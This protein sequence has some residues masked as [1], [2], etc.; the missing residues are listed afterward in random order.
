MVGGFK[1]EGVVAD[2]FRKMAEDGG[3]G[4]EQA[5]NTKWKQM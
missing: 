4:N 5:K 1:A 2:L 3:G